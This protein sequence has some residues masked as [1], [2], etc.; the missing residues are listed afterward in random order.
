MCRLELR[1]GCKLDQTWTDSHPKNLQL[2]LSIRLQQNRQ[3]ILGNEVGCEKIGANKKYGYLNRRKG[4]SDFLLPI[5]ARC[6]CL[7]L[8]I[9][10]CSPR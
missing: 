4:A 1:D 2:L 7:S 5:C 6:D 8:Q 10:S 3:F 9:L